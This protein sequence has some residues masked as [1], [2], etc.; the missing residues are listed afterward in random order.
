MIKVAIMG[1][2]TVGAGVY[3]AVVTNQKVIA[4]EIGEALE[5]KRILDLRKF[6]GDPAEKLITD[7][8]SDIE[9]DEEISLVVE[10][11]GGTTPAY[12]FV[13]AALLKGKHVVT[14]NKA[15]V[16]AHG[17]ELLQI[18]RDRKV[19]FF[20]EAAVGGGIPVI[21]TLG[22]GYQGQ[23]ITEITGILN[24]TTNYILTRMDREGAEFGDVLADAQR[25][26]YAERNPEADIEGHDTCRKIAILSSL[27]TGKEVNFE[28]V[29]T[30]G[31]SKID[32]TDFRY[33]LELKASIK[34]VGAAQFAGD[35]VTVSV[36]PLLV[37]DENPLYAVQGVYNGIVIKGNL[38]GTTMLYG[39]G[40]GKL[41][42]ASAV[43]ADMMEAAK[44]KNENVRFGWTAEKQ[45][46]TSHE[47]EKHRYFVRLSGD[48][49]SLAAAK[50]QFEAE[51]V[52]QL[53]GLE[54]V[55][56]V[57]APMTEF[58][59]RERA[60]KVPNILAMIRAELSAR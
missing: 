3:E 49:A 20:F 40:A 10:T 11:M 42:T 45:A 55:A 38:L 26:G 25:L 58:T 32:S 30:E 8:F 22:T 29:Y 2:G 27:V 9:E 24:G 54:E 52:I 28:D 12:E 39:S 44:H 56:I 19:N 7:K 15:L 35:Q 57:S 41:P 43:L 17:T 59:Y 46:V 16:A 4:A 21:R 23:V 53:P 5:V 18:A 36:F 51:R 6:P 1:Y 47:S 34:L 14:S 31:I 33:A 13:K 48:A 37:S 50:E 60:V